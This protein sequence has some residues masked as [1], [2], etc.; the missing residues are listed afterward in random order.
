[1]ID[2]WLLQLAS[3]WT[4]G[5]NMCWKKCMLLKRDCTIC[6]PQLADW[7][8][9]SKITYLN[10]TLIR[11]KMYKIVCIFFLLSLWS[12][13]ETLRSFVYHQSGKPENLFRPVLQLH[14]GVPTHPDMQP[15]L[16][17]MC[18]SQCPPRP[19]ADSTFCT[20]IFCGFF[21]HHG[22][23]SCREHGV[24]TVCQGGCGAL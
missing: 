6:I 16:P 21:S 8:V 12:K 10:I 19:E 2:A 15:K 13:A 4:L 24:G 11:F 5:T 9:S 1:M 3:V 7:S 14:T 18:S 22:D 23:Q 20:V 17:S